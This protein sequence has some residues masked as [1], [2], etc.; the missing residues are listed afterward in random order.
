[1]SASTNSSVGME[2]DAYAL[3]CRV[4]RDR[5]LLR[6]AE[7]LG[8]SPALTDLMSVRGYASGP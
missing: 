1:M 4:E 3:I 5:A 6:R 7:V 2:A 8:R